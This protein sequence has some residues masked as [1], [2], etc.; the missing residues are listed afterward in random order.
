MARSVRGGAASVARGG[1]SAKGRLAEVEGRAR[2]LVVEPPMTTSPS[3]EKR[4]TAEE[5]DALE[6]RVAYELVDGRLVELHSS[7]WTSVASTWMRVQLSRFVDEHRLGAVLGRDLGIRIHPKDPTHTRRASGL[8]LSRARWPAGD[9][10][11]LRVAPELVVEVVSPG[12]TAQDV[13]AKV[14]EWLAHGVRMVWVAFPN[15]REVHVYATGMHP[16]IYTAEDEITAG[17]ILPGFRSPVAALFP[18]R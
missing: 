2:I 1:R 16:Q 7:F 9:P 13:R 15:A 14:D 18:A 8:F 3:L 12:D 5:Y 6:D 11:Y 10:P 17:D 4:Y